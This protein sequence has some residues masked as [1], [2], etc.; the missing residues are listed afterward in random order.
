M[1]FF[2]KIVLT[3]SLL[4]SSSSCIEDAGNAPTQSCNPCKVFVTAATSQ[5]NFGTVTAADQ[6]CAT[7]TRHPGDGTYKALVAYENG[8]RRAC[9]TQNCQTGGKSE[10]ADWVLQPNATYTRLDG[11]VIGTTNSA[12]LFTFPLT[13]AISATA[14]RA[15]TGLAFPEWTTPTGE[16]C[17]N[18]TS[19]AAS[20]PPGGGTSTIQD[21]SS[22]NM[23]FAFGTN[24]NQ[25][26]SLICVEQ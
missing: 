16:A 4:V 26:N 7:D 15:W 23:A 25:N 18:W 17:T 24:C 10:G 20:A 1:K 6:I 22:F 5:G 21:G 2:T 9:T 13:N 8:S 11:T 19:T 14:G 12:A 3:L